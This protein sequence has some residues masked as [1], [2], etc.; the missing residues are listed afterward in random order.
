MGNL[1]KLVKMFKDNWREIFTGVIIVLLALTFVLD[2]I[3]GLI[4]GAFLCCIKYLCSD[5][6][7]TNLTIQCSELI[8]KDKNAN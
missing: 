3:T 1:N 6:V 7:P 8:I 2:E 4:S 5:S